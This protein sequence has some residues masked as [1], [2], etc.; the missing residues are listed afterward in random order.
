MSG[1]FRKSGREDKRGQA[2]TEFALVAPFFFLLT[3]GVIQLGL[4]FG[5]QNGLVS[6]ARELAR[7]AAPYHV[8]TAANATNVCNTA[9]S[10]HGVGTQLTTSLQRALP[11][12]NSSSVAVRHITYHWLAN[13]DGTYS[14]QL[15]VHLGYKYPLYIPLIANFLDAID[16]T[17][18]MALRLDAT[19]TMRIE[20]TGLTTSY[21]DVGCDV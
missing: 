18:D 21:S 3:F 6:A 12:Y 8:T 7:Y 2:I 20:N 19:E 11:G 17:T 9:S 1:R 4:L 5:G 16:G 15:T 13:A 14:V 10:D